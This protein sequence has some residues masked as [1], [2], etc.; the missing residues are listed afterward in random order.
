MTVRLVLPYE[1]GR[2]RTHLKA[3]DSESKILRFGTPVTNEAIDVLCDKIEADKDNHI[4]FC[5]ENELLE[6]VAVGHIAI[7]P[8]ME[9]AFSVWQSHQRQGLG[10]ALMKRVIQYCRT[11]TLLAGTMVCLSHNE[12]IKHLCKKHGIKVVNEYGESMANIELASPNITTFMAE[13]TDS[14][15]AIV[16][17]VGK[18]M[19][20]PWTFRS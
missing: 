12:A 14:N 18:R 2:Y 8:T 1:Y 11:H 10:S 5:V 19:P 13:A 7:G 17:Y 20:K 9:L 6:F 4:L 3:L 16:D 15:L